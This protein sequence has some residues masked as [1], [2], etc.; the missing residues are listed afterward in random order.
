MNTEQIRLIIAVSLSALVLFTWQMFFAPKNNPPIINNQSEIVKEN[1]SATVNDK[2]EVLSETYVGNQGNKPSVSSVNIEGKDASFTITNELT[3]VDAKGI[4][5]QNSILSTTGQKNPVEIFIV[6]EN[7]PIK[8]NFDIKYDENNQVYHGND[9]KNGIKL[10]LKMG[11]N[12]KLFFS[13]QSNNNPIYEIKLRGKQHKEDQKIRQFLLFS[14]DIKR[15]EIGD[16]E[17]LDGFIKWAGI[18][19]NYHLLAIVFSEKIPSKQSANINGELVINFSNPNNKLEG[20]FIYQ[21]KN[22][23]NLVKAGDNLQAAVDFGMFAVVAVPILRGLQFFYKYMPNY[24]IAIILLTLV[25]RIILLPLNYKSYKSMKKMQEIQPEM[26][27]LKEKFKDDPQRMQKETM[28]LFKRAGAN[29]LGGCLPLLLQLPIFFAFYQVLFSAVELV[30][31]P[32]FGWI[33]DLSAKDPFYVLPVLMTVTMFVQQK[34]MPSPTTDPTQKKIMLFMPL[35][36]GVIMKDLPAGLTLYIFV[37]TLVGI[38][39]QY[40]ISMSKK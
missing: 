13:L 28:E 38:I 8:L 33:I 40:V 7:N 11:E 25:V 15:V 29:P 14:K 5:S 17:K 27:K 22:Y 10:V 39:Q 35:V 16:D 2:T 3:F 26:N 1:I 6:N 30:G 31:A 24:G 18:D 4:F 9:F 36:F 23:D 21:Q 32:F 34:F 12:G 37:S 20:Y 19:F